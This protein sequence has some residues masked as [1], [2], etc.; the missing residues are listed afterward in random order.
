[1]KEEFTQVVGFNMVRRIKKADLAGY[2]ANGWK[3]DVPSEAPKKKAS[4][5][6][7]DK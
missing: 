2:L 3:E 4:K 5:K 7:E 6:K 1:M